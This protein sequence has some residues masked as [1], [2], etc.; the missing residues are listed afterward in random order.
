MTRSERGSAT[1]HALIAA[2]LLLTALAA[3]T[4]WSA[5]STARHKLAA[6]ADL[7]ALSAAQSLT[8]SPVPGT[9]E[10]QSAAPSAASTRSTGEVLQVREVGSVF[11]VHSLKNDSSGRL[12]PAASVDR[13]CVIAART[14]ALNGVRLRA[15]DVTSAAVM[16]EVSVELDLRVVHPVL[17]AAARAGPA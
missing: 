12:L 9:A 16:V 10:P 8:T 2:T 15:C 3:A 11:G 4:L 13:A 1:I 5:I 6:A 17:T 7:T 14:A